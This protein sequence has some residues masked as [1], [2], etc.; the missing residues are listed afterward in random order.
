MFPQ[1]L[2]SA[3]AEY[4]LKGQMYAALTDNWGNPVVYES[5]STAYILVSLGRDG[6][7]DGIDYWNVR[8]A[9]QSAEVCEDA[10]ADMIASDIQWHRFCGK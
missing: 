2:S 7:P 4:G 3:V 5:R 8:Q 10:N 9:N 1:A 6:Q